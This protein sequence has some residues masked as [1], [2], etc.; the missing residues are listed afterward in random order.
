MRMDMPKKQYIS[1]FEFDKLF[2]DEE[3]ARAFYESLRWPNGVICPTCGGSEGVYRVAS[4]KPQPYRCRACRKYFSVTV[5]TMMEHSRVPLRTWLLVTYMM[6]V[7]RKGI[8][9]HHVARETG[10]TQRSAWYL[11]HRIRDSWVNNAGERL[12]GV[13]EVDETYVGGRERNKHSY[14]RLRQGGGTAGKAI[15]FGMRSRDTGRVIAFP[16]EDAQARTISRAIARHV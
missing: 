8:S 13:I 3:A 9:S 1:R 2:P 14:K 4:Q 15:V 7:A 5:G 11:L 16:I 6:T 10:I 12:S